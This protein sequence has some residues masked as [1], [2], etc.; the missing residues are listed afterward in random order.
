[1]RR[2]RRQRYQ[3]YG[4]AVWLVI[5]W[6]GVT[7]AASEAQ[8]TIDGNISAVAGSPFNVPVTYVASDS[9]PASL[10]L[11]TIIKDSQV[12]I[13]S[14]ATR[15]CPAS[16]P[17][18]A[19]VSAALKQV[20]TG[21]GIDADHLALMEEIPDASGIPQL[22]VAV[23]D[24]RF[25]ALGLADPTI[26]NLPLTVASSATGT[27]PLTFDAAQTNVLTTVETPAALPLILT[28]GSVVLVSSSGCDRNLDGLCNLTD[29]FDV[30][31]IWVKADSGGTPTA[32]E[33][34]MADLAPPTGVVDLSDVFEEFSRWVANG[35]T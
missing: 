16:N 13:D 28:P 5:G 12:S 25:P 24:L 32:N 8:L 31:A 11:A 9:G 10:F 6:G 18:C 22:V 7:H 23:I 1:M 34:A 21:I 30:F 35:G 27:L 3:R 15:A 26:M 19:D 17:N 14:S 4:M 2:P 29:V 20:T 33:L